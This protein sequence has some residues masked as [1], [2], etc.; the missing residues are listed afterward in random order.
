MVRERLPREHAAAHAA[1]RTDGL[2]PRRGAQRH[3]P[4]RG[5]QDRL[6]A[7]RR[8]DLGDPR[9]RPVPGVL[10][11]RRPRHDDPRE[12]LRAVDRDRR[13]LH[14]HAA[15]LGARGLHVGDQQRAACVADHLLH[16]RAVD[17]RRAGG[18]PD[19]APL[20]QRRAAPIPRGSRLWRGARCTL[21]ARRGRQRHVQGEGAD[22]RR[23]AR[24]RCQLRLGRELHEADPA[25]VARAAVVLAPAAQSRSLVLLAGR[26]GLGTA[27]EARGRRTSASS[28]SRRRS[29]SR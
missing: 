18:V 2:L 25:E 28:R 9:L 24:R 1:L 19:E 14:D 26:E 7:G 29:T 27:A 8:P 17:P 15:H 22:G 13:G 5:R 16:D 6:D 21:R 23:H 3:Q 12:Q 4:V 11:P 20:H 10:P